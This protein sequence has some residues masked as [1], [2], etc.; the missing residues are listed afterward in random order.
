MLDAA[1][2][3]VVPLAGPHPNFVICGVPGVAG[4]LSAAAHLGRSGVRF[5]VWS[6]SLF[7]GDPTA[8]CTE[9]LRGDRRAALRRYP[10]LKG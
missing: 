1:R 4:L 2:A 3:G 6:D 9:P 7:G 10:L 5:H 8:I